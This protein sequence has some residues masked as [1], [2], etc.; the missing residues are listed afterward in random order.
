MTR[1]SRFLLSAIVLS[2]FTV[3]LGA[4]DGSQA[5]AA[6]PAAGSR[7]LDPGDLSA[8]KSIRATTWSL[9]GKVFAYQ[10]APNEGDAEVVIKTIADG[11]E[12]RHA[13]G[14]LPT[15]FGG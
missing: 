6:R 12:T 2:V 11:K 1:S 9:D 5:A 13:I 7:V 14:E 15:G 3:Q 10:F 8:W 4:Q